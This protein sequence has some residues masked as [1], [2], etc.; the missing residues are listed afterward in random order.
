MKYFFVLLAAVHVALAL[1][2]PTL[3]GALVAKSAAPE[4][5]AKRNDGFLDRRVTRL[6]PDDT[7]SLEAGF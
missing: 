1:P 7:L 3:Q 6:N 5:L 4:G 2:T